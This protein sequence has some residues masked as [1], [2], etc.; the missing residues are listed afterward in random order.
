MRTAINRRRLVH[1]LFLLTSCVGMGAC[2]TDTESSEKMSQE[3]RVRPGG[4]GVEGPG[5]GTEDPNMFGDI[6]F[7]EIQRARERQADAEAAEATRVGVPM[8]SDESWL[9]YNRADNPVVTRHQAMTVTD[10]E[11]FEIFSRDHQ[12][13]WGNNRFGAG[14]QIKVSA[15]AIRD[16]FTANTQVRGYANTWARIWKPEDTHGIFTVD[17]VANTINNANSQWAGIWYKVMAFDKMV[18]E[19]TIGAGAFRREVALLD[20]THTVIP[21][22]VARFTVWGVPV[23]VSASVRANE[24]IKVAGKVWI[25][26]VNAS[27][28]PGGSMWVNAD[29]TVGVRGL[30]AGMVRGMLRLVDVSVPITAQAAWQ[31]GSDQGGQCELGMSAGSNVDWLIRELA[32]NISVCAEVIGWEKCMSV[33]SWNGFHQRYNLFSESGSKHFGFGPCLPPPPAPVKG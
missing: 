10:P 11:R 9:G 23:S 5:L 31:F 1:Q 33:A 28:V 32:G 30:L 22:K 20:R 12:D 29:V 21:E 19:N 7:N 17:V 8:E 14:Y 6:D 24:Y 27:I 16:N 25:D 2:N 18:K 15:H 3:A 26:E 13:E 4:G